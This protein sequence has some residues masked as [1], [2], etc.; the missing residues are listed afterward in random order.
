MSKGDLKKMLLHTAKVH[1]LETLAEIATAVPTVSYAH[2]H[3]SLFF[4]LFLYLLK[5]ELRPIDPN[6]ADNNSHSQNGLLLFRPFSLA[7]DDYI[8]V[9][10]QMK[11]TWE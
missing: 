11:P 4:Y 9:C 10:V 7:R 8:H 2:P 5:A 6:D 3:T 1:G